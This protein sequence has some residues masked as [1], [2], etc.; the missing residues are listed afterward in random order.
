MIYV[1]YVHRKSWYS[2]WEVP[3]FT[4]NVSDGLG[5]LGLWGPDLA[6]F[7]RGGGCGSGVRCLRPE[8]WDLL[9]A[10]GLD[11][12]KSWENDGKMWDMFVAPFWGPGPYGPYG[13]LMKLMGKM[14][15]W[16]EG[17]SASN[18]PSLTFLINPCKTM[19]PL[20]DHFNLWGWLG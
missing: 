17:Q 7:G 6:G 1:V 14:G 8:W 3:F 5:R 20:A 16:A 11:L 18:S 4:V 13:N 15:N 2:W 9:E 10:P 19:N 12:G